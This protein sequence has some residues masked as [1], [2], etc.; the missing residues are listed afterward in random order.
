MFPALFSSSPPPPKWR[1]GFVRIAG[2]WVQGKERVGVWGLH[3]THKLHG[4]LSRILQARQQP[5]PVVTRGFV[6]VEG[7]G[8]CVCV[9]AVVRQPPT[10]HATSSAK[11][12]TR[13]S[14]APDAAN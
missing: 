7:G 11:P 14:P 2:G 1:R 6:I 12:C 4:Q 13:T 8:V 3:T 5:S 10:K 9:W